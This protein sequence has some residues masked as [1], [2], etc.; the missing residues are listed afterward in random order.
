MGCG[1]MRDTVYLGL[2]AVQM[3]GYGE[4]MNSYRFVTENAA[5]V[6]H[7]GETYSIREG[8]PASFVVMDAGNY[9]EALSNNAPVVLSVR[10]GK[11]IARTKPAVREIAE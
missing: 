4:I 1:S 8:N 9:H 7:L 5:K 10:K 6:L 11:A 2:H 3:M